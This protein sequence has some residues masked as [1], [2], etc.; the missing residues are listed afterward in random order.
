[1]VVG[2]KEKV[3]ET[4]RLDCQNVNSHASAFRRLQWLISFHYTL[5]FLLLPLTRP[6]AREAL[7]MFISARHYRLMYYF[8]K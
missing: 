3:M 7:M 2:M 8:E 4:T 1:M 5:C 6:G